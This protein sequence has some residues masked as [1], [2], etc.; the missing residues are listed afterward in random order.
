MAK[1][2]EEHQPDYWFV[3]VCGLPVRGDSFQLGESITLNRL[4]DPLSV[5]D[6]AGA[7][8]V[9]FREWAVLE[10]LASAATAELVSP[11]PAASTPGHD[12]LN[13]CWLVSALLVLRGFAHHICPA[14]STYSWT[15]VA[16]H[17]ARTSPTFHS[18]LKE[19]G[20]DKAVYEPRASLPPFRGGLL[21]YHLSVLVPKEVRNDPFDQA[22]AHWFASHLEHFSHLAANDERFRFALE[23]AVDWR[24]GRD[25]RAAIARLWA[26][27]E[28]LLAVRSEL[29]FRVS[30]MASAILAPRGLQR[31]EEFNRVKALYEVRS[32]AVHGEPIRN[33][34]LSQAVHE[35]FDLLRQL[36]LDAV[37]RGSVRTAEEYQREILC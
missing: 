11:T 16:G 1:A 28:A 33:A 34:T 20:I 7:G 31:L 37:E 25:L 10:P 24:Y 29:V 8:A 36:L 17:Q 15:L 6:L 5:F 21:E 2:T 22:E 26:G 18:Q 23:A 13:K 3:L 32:K 30:L 27:I 19:E 12:A 35:S 4:P 14:A 9:G